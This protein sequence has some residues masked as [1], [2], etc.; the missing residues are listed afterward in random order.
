MMVHAAHW[1]DAQEQ[2]P[3]DAEVRMA[4]MVRDHF[5]F[6]WQFLRRLGLG[7]SDADDATQSAFLIASQ[8]L[9]DI[10]PGAERAYL[11][12][13]AR[14]V[15]ANARVKSRR[16]KR[17]MAVESASVPV[18]PSSPDEV[19]DQT[20]ARDLLDAALERLPLELR[21]VFILADIEGIPS[22]EI[23]VMQGLSRG[24]VASRLRRARERLGASMAEA[25]G[26]AVAEGEAT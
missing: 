8:K 10:E 25:T 7:P 21:V 23:A 4:G 16:E 17:A 9:G 1:S 6:V 12:G 20:R 26:I 11:Y 13:V 2:V 19:L 14:R 24:T 5:V 15:A 22:P 3:V 18:G